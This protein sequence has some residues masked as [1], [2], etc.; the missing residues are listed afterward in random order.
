MLFAW[1][2]GYQFWTQADKKGNF[3]IHNV[4]PGTYD[5]YAFVP[6]AIGDYIREGGPIVVNPGSV[7]CQ[8]HRSS[9]SEDFKA[10]LVLCV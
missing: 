1:G 5:L 7:H 4:R 9:A 2:Q 10:S 3:T 8:L 6:G